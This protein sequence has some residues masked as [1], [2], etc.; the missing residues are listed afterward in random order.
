MG[1]NQIPGGPRAI[2]PASDEKARSSDRRPV[3]THIG[4]SSSVS[5]EARLRFEK[6]DAE[7][8]ASFRNKITEGFYSRKDVIRKAVENML[9]DLKGMFKQ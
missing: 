1:V 4:D 2:D 3:Q 8:L 9:D 6:A 5:E 7:R